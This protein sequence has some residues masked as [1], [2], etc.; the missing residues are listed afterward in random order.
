MEVRAEAV[1]KVSG[2]CATSLKRQRELPLAAF[3]RPAFAIASASPGGL[4]GY[5]GLIALRQSLVLQ[6]GAVVVP[7][8]VSVSKA[9]EAFEDDGSLKDERSAGFL[10]A[11][12]AK[13]VKL[14]QGVEAFTD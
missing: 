1:N 3:E 9:H 8:M 12:S 13:L 11:L 5:R 4:G 2:V 14:A 10:R 7:Q 6:L